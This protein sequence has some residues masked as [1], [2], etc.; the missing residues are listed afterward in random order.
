MTALLAF[1][2]TFGILILG[3]ILRG[4]VLVKFWGWFIV[5]IFALPM[6]GIAAAI[7]ISMTVTCLTW[8]YIP[9]DNADR[10]LS[11]TIAM[12]VINPVL[13][14]LTGWVVTLFL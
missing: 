8:Q 12:T 13:A 7:G 11:G 3:A 10:H 14:L 1:I 9:D 4:F 2:G 5:P 6:F